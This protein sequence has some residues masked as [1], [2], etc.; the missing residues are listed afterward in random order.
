M[1]NYF[2]LGDWNAICDGC[3]FKFKASQLRKRW[4]GMMMCEDDW[5][6]RNPLDFLRPPS[7]HTSVP[8]S[9]PEATDVFIESP[10]VGLLTETGDYFLLTEEEEPIR[11][12][13]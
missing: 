3:G 9:R 13:Q 4:D 12:E 6:I 8:W 7:E 11:T 1:R 2:K 10:G 5:E